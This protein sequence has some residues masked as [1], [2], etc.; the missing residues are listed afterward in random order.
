MGCI[1]WYSWKGWVGN[2]PHGSSALVERVNLAQITTSQELASFWEQL[3]S[4]VTGRKIGPKTLNFYATIISLYIIVISV[5][6]RLSARCPFHPLTRTQPTSIEKPKSDYHDQQ[7]KRP[8]TSAAKEMA[9]QTSQH[10]LQ[11]AKYHNP[12]GAIS[13]AWPWG[14]LA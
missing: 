3:D 11:T 4:P 9:P 14:E 1:G 2:A 8:S 6:V 7:P 13:P 12:Q 10:H 5:R